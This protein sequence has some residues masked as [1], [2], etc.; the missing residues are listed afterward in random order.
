M[1]SQLLVYTICLALSIASCK[2]NE[3]SRVKKEVKL[4][5][6]QHFDE[7]GNH[8]PDFDHDAFLGE[9]EALT[10]KDLSPEESKEKLGQ[11]FERVDKNGDGFLSEDELKDWI[12]LQ[13]NGALYKEVE[14]M[15]QA[16]NLDGDD[17][18]TW[19]EYNMTSFS[20]FPLEKLVTLKENEFMDYRKRVRHDK[21]RWSK[22]DVNRDEALDK[23]EF[24]AFAYPRE[25]QHMRDIAVSETM[26]DMDKDGDGFVSLE[27]YVNDLWSGEGSEPDWVA[28]ERKGFGE[29]RDQDGDGK[30]NSDEVAEWI[31]PSNYDPTMSEAKHLI[32]ET[33]SNKDKKLAKSEVLENFKL[34]VG[35]RVTN[36]GEMRHDEF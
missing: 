31:M 17:K 33:D 25:R 23:E 26:E 13:Q 9:E 7:H 5:D 32:H 1:K 29:Y 19:D 34:F 8:N 30:L 14:R 16:H 28:M 20:G 36:F 4:S 22:A 12:E 24:L 3:S 21:A 10:F 11:L 18:L 15:F 35:S 27:E 6:K 2:P